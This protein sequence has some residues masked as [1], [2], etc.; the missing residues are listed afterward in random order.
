MKTLHRWSLVLFVIR[1]T[2]GHVSQKVNNDWVKKCMKYEGEGSRPR[3]RL[4]TRREVVEKDCQTHKLNKEN[5][6]DRVH[7]GCLMMRMGVFLLIPDHT[8]SPGHRRTKT[9]DG[10]VCRSS[11]I[12]LQLSRSKISA[13]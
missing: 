4:E 12:T 5:V 2:Y 3:G 6:M 10:C 1:D 7:K 8:G 13:V 11:R 9:L